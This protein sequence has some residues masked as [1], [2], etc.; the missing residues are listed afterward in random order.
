MIK[1]E[2]EHWPHYFGKHALKRLLKGYVKGIL[3]LLAITIVLVLL[4][5]FTKL[6]FFVWASRG[7]LFVIIISPFLPILSYIQRNKK[8]PS[9]GVNKTGFLLNER[10]WN[11]AF[12]TWDEIKNLKEFMHPDFGK[13]LHFEFVSSTKAINKEGQD[14]FAQSLMREYDIE[15]QPKKISSQLVKGDLS[16]F[17]NRF[18][19]HYN[20][21]KQKNP[22]SSTEAYEIAYAYIKENNLPFQISPKKFSLID[23]IKGLNGSLYSFPINDMDKYEVLISTVKK[24]VEGIQSEK[25]I[26]YPHKAINLL[27]KLES[28]DVVKKY[29]GPNLEDVKIK[30]A[31]FYFSGVY[32]YAKPCWIVYTKNLKATMEGTLDTDYIVDSERKVVVS[33][34]TT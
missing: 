9:Y 25:R 26:D 14:K 4:G 28:I 12:F 3:V 27:T 16:A 6:G 21:Y 17:I 18:K 7:F 1:F 2:I 22:I 32:E 10:G 13:E 19:Q 5:V 29:L 34:I 33:F 15:K 11:A 8:V 30:H 24:E 23:G 31:Y 20:A